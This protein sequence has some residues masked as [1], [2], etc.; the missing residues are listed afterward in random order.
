MSF[1]ISTLLIAIFTD[2]FRLKNDPRARA[3]IDEISAKIA[4]STSPG[5]S[6]VAATR[7]IACGRDQG[8]STLTRYQQLPAEELGNGGRS[9]GNRAALVRRQ[10]TAG[11]DFIIPSPA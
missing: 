7:S 11:L 9:M 8:Y 2:V 4:C 6:T 5:A 1:S 10:L 3:A